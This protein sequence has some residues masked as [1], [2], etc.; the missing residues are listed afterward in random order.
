MRGFRVELGEIESVMLGCAEIVAAAVILDH[1][2]AAV[3]G[4]VLVAF[5][6]ARDGNGPAPEELRALVRRQLPEPMVPNDFIRLER[7][8]VLASGKVAREKL[9]GR[10]IAAG[11]GRPRVGPRNRTE[12][13]LVRLWS[14][15]LGVD[16]AAVGVDN[17]FLSLGGHSLNALSLLAR[18]RS[19]LGA[20]VPLK[21]LYE[22]QTIGE[23]AEQIAGREAEL[24]AS[25]RAAELLSELQGLT[26]EAIR[27]LIEQEKG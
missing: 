11:P 3:G 25:R 2:S 4:A 9:R 6:T 12:E 26:P 17:D 15:V 7:M 18:L 14:E 19:E 1:R 23:I 22:G 16:A 8:P 27:A 24:L 5:Y 20:E 13:R 10:G 21:A